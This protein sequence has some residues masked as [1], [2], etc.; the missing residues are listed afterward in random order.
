LAHDP[1]DQL[2]DGRY[3]VNQALNLS[4]RP[5]AGIE[6]AGLINDPPA[7]ARD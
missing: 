3:V 5:N 2:R 7:N 1:L 4:C 6:I